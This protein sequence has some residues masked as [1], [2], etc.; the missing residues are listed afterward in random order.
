M[1]DYSEKHVGKR[2][3]SQSG[4]TVGTVDDV[5]DG[6][7]YVT[8]DADADAETLSELRWDGP[9]HQD[10]ERLADEF[11]SNITDETV[12]LRV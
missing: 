12:R 6:D 1:A 9:V 7:L 8:V 10:T 5:R 2:V 3:V 4:G 11:V